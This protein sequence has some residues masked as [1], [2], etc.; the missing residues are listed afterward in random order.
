MAA[1][2]ALAAPGGLLAAQS[3]LPKVHFTFLDPDSLPPSGVGSCVPPTLQR[4][5]FEK[6]ADV[7][8]AAVRHGSGVDMI[9]DV[10]AGAGNYLFSAAEMGAGAEKR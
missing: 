4:G 10:N 7:L 5:T 9:D 2:A 6:T 3:T 8:K 1:L